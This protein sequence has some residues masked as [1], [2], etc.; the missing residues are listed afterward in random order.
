MFETSFSPAVGCLPDAVESGDNGLLSIILLDMVKHSVWLFCKSC[1]DFFNPTLSAARSS[2]RPHYCW[3]IFCSVS[4]SS[5]YRRCMRLP[6]I[7][8]RR[9]VFIRAL[10][11]G[12]AERLR[13]HLNRCAPKRSRDCLPPDEKDIFG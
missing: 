2:P 3:P 7:L 12:K 5:A 11:N 13:E 1:A 9:Y 8:I 4:G 10:S 6:R